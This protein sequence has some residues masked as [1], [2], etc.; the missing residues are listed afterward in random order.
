MV[1]PLRTCSEKNSIARFF[2][3]PQLSG[4]G[5]RLMR[6][7]SLTGRDAAHNADELACGAYLGLFPERR[8][9]L[10]IPGPQVVGACRVSALQELVVVRIGGGMDRAGRAY[11]MR[12]VHDELQNL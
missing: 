8:K 7:F 2:L 6:F 11:G 5:S 10:S 9:M 1:P 4:F 12:V 3:I